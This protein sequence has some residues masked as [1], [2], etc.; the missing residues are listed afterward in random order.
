MDVDDQSRIRLPAVVHWGGLRVK[1]TTYVCHGFY[2]TNH[3]RR[4]IK[5]IGWAFQ[6][7]GVVEGGKK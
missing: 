2:V 3:W 7:I 5:N 1:D 4:L 6:N